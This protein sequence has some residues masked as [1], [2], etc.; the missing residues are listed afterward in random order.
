MAI[1]LRLKFEGGTQEQYEAVNA[2]MGV[3]DNPPDGLV[4]HAAG[5]IEDGWG[6]IDFWES[7]EMFDSFLGGRRGQAI[8]ELGDDALPGPPDVKEFP[9]HNI[10]QP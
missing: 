6:I 4:F 3:A 7:R 1:G 9:V 8:Q 2:K 10:I 5:P